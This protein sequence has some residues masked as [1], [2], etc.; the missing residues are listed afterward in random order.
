ML[1]SSFL[2]VHGSFA[3][4]PVC[5]LHVLLVLRPEEG[6]GSPGT[7]LNIVATARFS[8]FKKLFVVA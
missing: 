3:Y 2:Y 4:M 8:F 5:A 6:F 1:S 7:K